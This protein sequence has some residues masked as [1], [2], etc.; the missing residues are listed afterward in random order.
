MAK[1]GNIYIEKMGVWMDEEGA[2]HFTFDGEH[3]SVISDP[4]SP[5]G[6]PTFYRR[7]RDRLERAG[8][9]HPPKE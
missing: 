3:C 9:L 2:I 8:K 7:L 6:H 1:G 5:C 4:A